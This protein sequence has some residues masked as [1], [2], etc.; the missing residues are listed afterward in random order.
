MGFTCL[1]TGQL[2]ARLSST[3]QSVARHSQPKLGAERVSPASFVPSFPW[4]AVAEGTVDLGAAYG[5]G[6]EDG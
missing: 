2:T 3:G 1:R 5:L 6:C 4:E